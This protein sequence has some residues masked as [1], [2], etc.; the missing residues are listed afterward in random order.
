[1]SFG[2]FFFN[3]L[4][5]GSVLSAQMSRK[6]ESKELLDTRKDYDYNRTADV[7][8]LP[9]VLQPLIFIFQTFSGSHRAVGIE[10]HL[11]KLNME[12]DFYCNF[13]RFV[14]LRPSD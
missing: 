10:R 11:T 4:S 9:I 13:S 6:W 8:G 14:R 5:R 12:I 2:L 3:R 7:D 1:M